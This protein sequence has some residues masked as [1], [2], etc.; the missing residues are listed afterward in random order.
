M[1]LPLQVVQDLA[2]DQSSL[3]AAKKLLNTS[4]WPMLG[5]A[6]ELN[7]IWGQ[8]QGSGANPYLTMADVVDH[9]YKC[10]CP[11]RKF[12]CKHVLALMW[13]FSESQDSFNESTPPDWVGE[14]LSRRRRSSATATEDNKPSVAKNIATAGDEEPM[15]SPEQLAKNA[16]QKQ[17]RALAAQQASE[18]S[19]R[20][21]LA[22]LELWIRDQQ[23]TGLSGLLKDL[24]PRVRRIAARLVDAKA[25]ALASRVDELPSLLAGLPFERQLAR[26]IEE[27]GIWVLL[28]RAWR[29][30]PQDPDVRRALVG[31]ENREQLLANVA[32]GVSGRW[33]CL[34]ER[35]ETRRD[36]LVSHATWLWPLDGQCSSG[37]MLLDYY[38]A[39][40]GKREASLRA[41][42][43]LEGELVFY[44]SRAPQR[45]ILTQYQILAPE[46]VSWPAASAVTPEQALFTLRR[47][48]PWET[49]VPLVLGPCRLQQ[50]EDGGYWLSVEEQLIPVKGRDLPPLAQGDLQGAFVCWRGDG[51][52]LLSVCTSAW[53]VISC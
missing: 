22:E 35:I 2:P 43:L 42:T 19:I 18:Q 24:R 9:G 17:K 23:R 1:E 3:G 33:L 39:T 15:L 41:G 5:V 40:A 14:W 47:S 16:A 34:G 7:S 12:P 52:E 11:S 21:G 50:A 10:T 46:A 45:A 4:K 30:N 48:L 6:S 27:L 36:G 28:S 37:A 31:A 44:P 51:A 29:I 49:S 26:L 38:P 53:G 25:S 13:I 20:E 8:C 32:T